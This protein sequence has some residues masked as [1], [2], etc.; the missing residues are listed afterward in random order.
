MMAGQFVRAIC[1]R[2]VCVVEQG[3]PYVL[4]RAVGL[5]RDP[6]PDPLQLAA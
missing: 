1:K 2:A 4:P 6:A 3:A 5:S